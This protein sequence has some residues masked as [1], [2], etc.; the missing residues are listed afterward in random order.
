M[1]L[2]Q[3]CLCFQRSNLLPKQRQENMMRHILLLALLVQQWVTIARCIYDISKDIEEQLNDKVR[4]SF[5]AL[6]VDEAT[7][8]NKD[9]LLI[10]YVRFIDADDLRD[11]LLYCKQVTGRATAEELIKILDTYLKETNLKWED[12]MGICTDGSQAMAGKRGMQALIKRV[13]PN[14][15]WTHFMIHREALA[16]KQLS[17]ELY[18]VISDIIATV[19]YIKTRPVKAWIFSVLCEEMGADYTALLFHS[20]SRWLSCGKVL[21]RVFEL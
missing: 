6:Q 19:N 1:N 5:F 21:S 11:E 4:D 13:S 15:Q 20:D 10:T 16:F 2:H 14:V 7:D 3:I 8:S 18:D 9:C 12:C 17:P